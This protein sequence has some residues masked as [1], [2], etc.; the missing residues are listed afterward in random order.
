MCMVGPCHSFV[1]GLCQKMHKCVFKKVKLINHDCLP[2]LMLLYTKLRK[3][4]GYPPQINPCGVH[5]QAGPDKLGLR[6]DIATI[7]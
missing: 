7:H 5:A 6:Q 1:D 3:G 2:I 4:E